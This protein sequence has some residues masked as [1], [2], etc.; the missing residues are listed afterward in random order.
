MNVLLSLGEMSAPNFEPL[1]LIRRRSN[2]HAG[3]ER[4]LCV[5]KTSWISESGIEDSFDRHRIIRY[6]LVNI[7]CVPKR[8]QG[9][10]TAIARKKIEP[11]TF[12]RICIG[13]EN[14]ITGT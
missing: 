2:E 1:N 12:V 10:R 6:S 3:A 5:G 8:I 4:G 9:E 13:S 11:N 14:K 7:Y